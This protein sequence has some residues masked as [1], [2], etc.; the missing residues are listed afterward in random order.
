MSLELTKR[1]LGRGFAPSEKISIS[2]TVALG[3]CTC[4]NCLRRIT[5]C[6]GPI[7]KLVEGTWSVNRISGLITFMAS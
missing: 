3:C 4:G 5:G 1:E 2:V 6:L 7:R